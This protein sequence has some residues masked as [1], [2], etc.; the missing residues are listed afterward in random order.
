MMKKYKQIDTPQ[1][2]KLRKDILYFTLNNKLNDTLYSRLQSH[3]INNNR[4]ELWGKLYDQIL[5]YDII[6]D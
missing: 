5:D 6:M 1:L 2:H 4:W 3:L